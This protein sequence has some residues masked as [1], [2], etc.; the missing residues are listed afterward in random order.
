MKVQLKHLSCIN[1]LE[2]NISELMERLSKLGD[3]DGKGD[4]DEHVQLINEW[5]NYYSAEKASKCNS[6]WPWSDRP[7]YGLTAFPMGALS[8]NLIFVIDFLRISLPRS[9]S[10]WLK[11]IWVE[12]YK[13][14]RKASSL[15]LVELLKLSLK[16]KKMKNALC[17]G[18]SKMALWRII[19]PGQR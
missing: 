4:L 16:S 1:I 13:V 2:I 3:N 12:L 9:D 14:R 19:L 7:D 10:R 6:S 11:P 18:F 5:L 17:V 8:H 15:T